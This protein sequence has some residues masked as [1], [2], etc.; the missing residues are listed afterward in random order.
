MAGIKFTKGSGLNESIYGKS[1]EPI[2]AMVEQAVEA[3]EEKSVVK[4]IYAMENTKNFAEKLT[5]E[6][7][8]GGFEPV[9]RFNADFATVGRNE[10]DGAAHH[11]QMLCHELERLV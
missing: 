8:L 9:S 2:F 7:S 4:E 10:R 3:F 5:S 1:Q 11:V 6:T